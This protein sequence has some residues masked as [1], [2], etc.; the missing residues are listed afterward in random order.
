[1]DEFIKWVASCEA[2]PMTTWLDGTSG[3]EKDG[4]AMLECMQ[5]KGAVALNII[6]DRNWN[7]SDTKARATK[8]SNLKAIADAAVSMHLPIN[9]GT[10][11]NKLGL[12]FVDELNGEVLKLHRDAFLKGASIMVGHT[13]LLRYAD[14][15]YISSKANADHKNVQLKN[16][17]FE[18][19]GKL[20]AV[21]SRQ[22][23]TLQD[24]GHDKALA[25]FRDT[26]KG[27]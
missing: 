25:W 27:K 4:R 6:P 5:A 3:G 23:N 7:I 10:E 14:Y 12:P 16:A 17:F 21:T 1:V 26:V 9:I 22:A 13:V 19:V 2:I 20:P 15:S 24:M 11:M 18:A 8:V